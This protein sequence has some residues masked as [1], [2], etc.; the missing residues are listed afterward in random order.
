MAQITGKAFDLKLFTRVFRYVAPYKRVFYFALFLT[1]FLAALGVIRPVLIG[2]AIDVY[3][4]NNDPTGLLYLMLIVVGILFVEAGAQFYQTY[5]SNWLGQSVTI[6]LRSIL[7]NHITSFKLKYFDKTAIGTLVTRCISDIETISQI[8]SQG[9]LSIMGD[10]LKLIVV[11]GV[12]FAINWQLTLY[13]LVPIPI[14]IFAMIIFKNAIKRSFQQVRTQ[15]SRLNAFAQEHIV[16]MSIVQVFNRE[17]KEKEKFVNINR[18]HRK[19]HIKS[20][21]AYSIFFPVVEILSAVSLSLLI[22]WGVGGVI[23]GEVTMGDL[24]MFILFIHML[25]RPIRQ[26]ADRFNVLQMGMVGSER[27]FA[28][29]DTESHIQDSGTLNSGIQGSIKFR[30]VWFAYQDEDWVLKDLSFEAKPGETIAFVG[31]TGAGKSSIVNLINRFY[32]F[33]KGE[34]LIDDTPVQDYDL[35]YLRNE[36][37]VVLQDVFLFS[38]TVANNISLQNPAI[39]REEIVKAAEAVGASTF[40]EKLPGSY[41]YDVKER[42]GML[43]VGQRQLISFIRAYV[44]NPKILILD[45]ATSSVDTESEL[46]IQNAIDRLTENRTSIVIAHRL[47]TIQKADRIIVLEKGRIIEQGTH[48]QLLANEGHYK[49]LIDMQFQER[50]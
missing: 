43:S 2:K 48:Q 7:F 10:L 36:I 20:I 45:E 35:E 50:S 37:A 38:D 14:L 4:I 39:T 46:M 30:N 19:A 27:V 23:E 40:I 9:L 24:V 13:S 47:S 28:V 6:D 25:F 44:Y 34:I 5:Y 8:F 21:W 11:I 22:W 18:S 3:V 49:K 32:E 41:D 29:L 26:L 31:A 42:G 33:Q 16:G 12:M 15:V 17:S 1:I